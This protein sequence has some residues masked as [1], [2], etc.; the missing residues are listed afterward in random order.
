MWKNFKLKDSS[1]S[2]MEP[3]IYFVPKEFE[4]PLVCHLRA[5]EQGQATAAFLEGALLESGTHKLME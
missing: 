3:E 4:L 1:V 5:T 2:A